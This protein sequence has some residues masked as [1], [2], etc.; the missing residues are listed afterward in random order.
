MPLTK[1][2]A[3]IKK[4]MNKTYGKEKGKQVFYAS[5]NK[6]TIKGVHKEDVEKYATPEEKLFLESFDDW[7]EVHGENPDLDAK[8]QEQ[9]N[10][11]GGDNFKKF[12]NKNKFKKTFDAQGELERNVLRKAP[13]SW[14]G[15]NLTQPFDKYGKPRKY[16]EVLL[17]LE[18]FPGLTKAE[19]YWDILGK[20]FSPEKIHGQDTASMWSPLKNAGLIEPKRIGKKTVYHL[21]PN[22]LKYKSEILGMDTTPADEGEDAVRQDEM[23]I[24]ELGDGLSLGKK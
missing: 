4:A 23:G 7:D 18:R 19:I 24:S 12:K 22:W 2:G 14:T 17:G 21:G 20:D 16:L 5:A 10:P 8:S 3:K 6:G 13:L 9:G 1:K 15:A 11:E